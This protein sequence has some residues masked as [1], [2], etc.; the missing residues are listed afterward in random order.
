MYLAIDLGGISR[1]RR[2]GFRS[3]FGSLLGR[4]SSRAGRSGSSDVGIRGRSGGIIVAVGR[5]EINRATH[6]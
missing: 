1:R 6:C 3:R 2:G 4:R 5:Y